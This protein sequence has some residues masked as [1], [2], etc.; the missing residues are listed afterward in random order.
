MLPD[1]ASLTKQ[2]WHNHVLPVMAARLGI[3]YPAY[4]PLRGLSAEE[5]KIVN[6]NYIIPDQPAMSDADWKKLSDYIVSNA[7]DTVVIDESR[8]TRNAPL[9]AFKRQDIVL[10]GQQPSLITGLKYNNAKQTLWIGTLNN[11]VL[12][13]KYGRGVTGTI[14]TSSPA[15][16][17]VFKNDTTYLTQIG[18][19]YPTELSTGLISQYVNG[20]NPTLLPALHR[21][22]SIA[23]D[24]MNGD[25]LPEIV[26]CSFGNKTGQLSLFSKKKT[27]GNY[28]EKVLLKLPGAVKCYIRDMNG[29]GKKDIV[30]M[31]SQG[32]ESVYVFYQKDKLKFTS[33]RVLRFPPNYG[34]T[35]MVLTDFD[36]DGKTDII[37]VHGDNADYSNILKPYH[38]IR[39][40]INNGNGKFS[41]KYFYPIY[42]VTRVLAD[43][44]D[45]DGD[46]DL[47]AT[48]F[49]PEFTKLIDESFIYLENVDNKA[50]KFKSYTTKNA[51]PIKTLTLEKADVDGDGD[52]DI[53]TGH[54]A[55]S[56]GA[57]PDSLDTKWRSANYGLSI[58]YNQLYQPKKVKQ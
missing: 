26:V 34:T 35:D 5:K 31:F 30:A 36:R 42:G 33:S 11:K 20:T 55:Q 12:R 7:P 57:V 32:D 45:K 44:F 6:N 58:F 18:K 27:N 49:F 2:I 53:I 48:A 15:V 50:F 38:G 41:E 52:L 1:P 19:L 40:N 29:D 51:T 56:P 23:V 43:D 3:I 16:S 46:T 22:V 54:F 13:W 14:N 8:L 10:D 9:K 4:D 24:D 47:V 28:S 37:T 17:F 21:P 25:G 39:I